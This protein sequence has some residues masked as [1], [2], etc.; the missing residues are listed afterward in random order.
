MNKRKDWF[1]IVG[2]VV[3]LIVGAVV[4]G[5]GF[6]G[7]LPGQQGSLYQ[8]PQGRFTMNIDPSWEQVK[9]DGSYTQFKVAN[10]PMN[11]Y[12]LVLKANTVKDAFSQALQTTGFDP[13]LLTGGAVANFGDWQAYSQKDSA[14]LEYGLAGQIVGENAYVMLV[15]AEKPGVSVENAAVL[16][17]MGSLKISG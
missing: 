2:V 6:L 1:W 11:M 16:R 17:A 15:K 10:P 7:R 9:T 12:L 5:L 4:G 3:I 13:G 14:G 8:D